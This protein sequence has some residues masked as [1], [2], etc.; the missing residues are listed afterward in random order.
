MLKFMTLKK[1]HFSLN[2]N[3]ISLYHNQQRFDQHSEEKK[4]V[5]NSLSFITYL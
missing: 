1:T 4:I 3:F 5:W 2:L